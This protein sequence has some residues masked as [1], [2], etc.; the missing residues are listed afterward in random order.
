M[1]RTRQHHT[2]E[3]KFQVVLEV[4]REEQTVTEIAVKHQIHPNLITRWKTEFLETGPK[5]VFNR[6][7]VADE[8]ARLKAEAEDKEAKL[9]QEIGQLTTQL[10]WLKKNLKESLSRNERV[11]LI[12]RQD[13]Q[14]PIATQAD[15]LSL[16][17][18]SLYYKPREVSAL[19]LL[20]RRRIDEIHTFLPSAG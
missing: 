15:L 2:P 8:T 1:S 19:T 13:P 4:L 12:Q 9:Y 6:S 14:V 16:N 5:A 20:L 3:F 7:K 11:A 18:T 17:R 10:A